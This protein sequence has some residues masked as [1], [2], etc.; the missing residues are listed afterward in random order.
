M[1]P[2]QPAPLARIQTV[3][4]PVRRSPPKQVF[5]ALDDE[6]IESGMVMRV[7]LPSGELVADVIVGPDGR[8]RAIRIV[9]DGTGF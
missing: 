2:A 5:F 1:P 6:P 8:A 9:N 4:R 3:R 7:G